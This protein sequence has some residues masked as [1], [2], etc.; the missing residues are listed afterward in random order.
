M[1]PVLIMIYDLEIVSEF[2]WEGKRNK[3]KFKIFKKGHPSC[4]NKM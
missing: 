1:E 3:I 2:L 4:E